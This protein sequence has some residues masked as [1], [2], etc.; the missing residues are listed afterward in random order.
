MNFKLSP[1]HLSL[2]VPEHWAKAALMN[3][4]ADYGSITQNWLNKNEQVWLAFYNATERLRLAGK[5]TYGAKAVFEHLRYETAVQDNE[6]TFK[7]NNNCVSGLAR[8]YNAVSG[9]EFYQTRKST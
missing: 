8:L 7:L 2:Y 3:N 5:R 6:C 9:T 1:D 4:S